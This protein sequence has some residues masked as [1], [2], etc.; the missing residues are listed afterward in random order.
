[1]F[2]TRPEKTKARFAHSIPDE[3]ALLT[4]DAEQVSSLEAVDLPETSECGLW[5]RLRGS[6]LIRYFGRS[7]FFRNMSVVLGGT[8]VAQAVGVA[9]A[10]VISRLFTPSD[11]GVLGSF[12]SI[13]LVVAAFATLQYSQALMLPRNEEDAANVFGASLLSVCIVTLVALLVAYLRSDWLLGLLKAPQ[14]VWLLWFLPLGIFVAGINRSF[15]AWCVRR[16]AFTTTAS[17]QIL[18]AGSSNMLKIVFGILNQG[19]PGL[20][21]SS[22]AA[23]GIASM[24]LARRVLC[25]DKAL[26]K[27]SLNWRRIASQARVY[28]D[29]PVYSATQNTMNAVSQGL[30]VLMLAH[31]HGIAVAGAY[32]FGMKLIHVPMD[33]ILTALRQVLFQKA[34]ETHNQGGG[35][36]QLFIKTTGGLMAVALL[37]SIVVFIWAP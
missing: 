32:A 23:N 10:P 26:L 27:E 1:M 17:S 13:L 11:F 18:G 25:A 36:L 30:P 15:Q 29:F 5:P 35:L 12:N 14:S 37:P 20:I 2:G 3:A 22:V 16:K 19:S 8:V 4:A 6:A 28:R 24:S 31:F 34:S 7:Q 9:I 21:V 33:F